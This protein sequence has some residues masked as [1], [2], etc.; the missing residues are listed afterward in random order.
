M[1]I[2]NDPVSIHNSVLDLLVLGYKGNNVI[3]R[4]LR[5]VNLV[6][7]GIVF[8]SCLAGAVSCI[9]FSDYF[10]EE[11]EYVDADFEWIDDF[12]KYEVEIVHNNEAHHL[13]ISDSKVKFIYANEDFLNFTVVEHTKRIVDGQDHY[14]VKKFYINLKYKENIL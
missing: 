8:I 13:T 10:V 12:Q 1:D 4:K 6:L 3:M 2:I 9:L 7:I 14:S 5:I 11:L